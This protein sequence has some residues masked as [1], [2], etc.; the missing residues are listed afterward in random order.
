MRNFDRV[1]K[2]CGFHY[3]A[4]NDCMGGICFPGAG[5]LDDKSHGAIWS[6]SRSGIFSVL[7]FAL[8]C[9][10]TRRRLY[11]VSEGAFRL[12]CGLLLLWLSNLAAASFL[13]LSHVR[14]SFP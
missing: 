7:G 10:G 9:L 14:K 8:Q 12:W 13:T 6:F 1:G 4:A 11:L 3:L 2:I 5:K